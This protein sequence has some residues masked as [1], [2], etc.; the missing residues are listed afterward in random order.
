[1]RQIDGQALSFPH[2]MFGCHK[3]QFCSIFHSVWTVV[4]MNDSFRQDNLTEVEQHN[5][6]RPLIE[7]HF[8]LGVAYVTI[9]SVAL[10]VGLFGNTMILLIL[11]ANNVIHK[12]GKL[13]IINLVAADLCVAVVADPICILGALKGQAFFM[14]NVI[15]C[16]VA[17]SVCLTACFCAFM[18]LS[19]MTLHRYMYI[20]HPN[21][22]NRL[23][24]RWGCVSLCI[25]CWVGAFLLEMPNFLG[26]GGHYFDV[27]S[28]QCI[29]DRTASDSYT[30]FVSAFAIG[31][32]LFNRKLKHH[33][34][35]GTDIDFDTLPD[36]RNVRQAGR[37]L[38]TLALH[39]IMKLIMEVD[40]NAAVT[41]ADDGSKKQGS[42]SVSVQGLTINGV[43]RPLPTL[44]VASK[45]CENLSDLKNTVFENLS[46]ASGISTKQL[47][48]KILTDYISNF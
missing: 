21:L 8:K 33:D 46:A 1:M 23:Y 9:A 28:H 35:S 48:E 24:G 47:F 20:C 13:F 43:F 12:V 31:N 22:H 36:R 30:T 25:A 4:D 14:D 6:L 41:Y 40:G 39:E 27:K 18:S 45:T 2:N 29:W 11:L 44:E 16:E 10:C 42:G 26:W 3:T 5:F 34:A 15:F 17:A 19:I 37:R 32:K 7:T 38:E